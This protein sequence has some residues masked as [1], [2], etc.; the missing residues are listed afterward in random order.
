M[1]HTDPDS[2]RV[3]T[4]EESAYGDQCHRDSEGY[5]HTGHGSAHIDSITIEYQ[6]TRK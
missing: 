5:V 1:S 4:I 2:P 3:Y 6:E